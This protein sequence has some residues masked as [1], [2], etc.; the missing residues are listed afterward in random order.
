MPVRE[1][2]RGMQ[3]PS[4]SAL[5]T[6]SVIALARCWVLY[7]QVISLLSTAGK[8]LVEASPYDKPWHIG[9]RQS[10]SRAAYSLRIATPHE[11]NR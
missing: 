4:S 10:D 2:G 5:P 1:R 3:T 8:V 7:L 6:L 9:M 11:F